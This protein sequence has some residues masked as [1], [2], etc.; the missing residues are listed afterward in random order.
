MM[1]LSILFSYINSISKDVQWIPQTTYV[2]FFAD[3][4][5]HS[6]GSQEQAH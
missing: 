2:D 5:I 6:E 3:K 4:G 1:I